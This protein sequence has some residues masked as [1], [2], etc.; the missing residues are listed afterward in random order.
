[1]RWRTRKGGAPVCASEA[2]P[3]RPDSALVHE[4][5]MQPII[6]SAA[7]S[8]LCA[9]V[10]AL[11]AG[12]FSHAAGRRAGKAEFIVAVQA[13]ASEVIARLREEIDRLTGRCEAAEAAC[14]AAK[15]HHRA[16]RD[17]L[18]ALWAEVRAKPVPAYVTPKPLRARRTR[19]AKP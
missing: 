16:C 4:S 15:E 11:V 14:Q 18:D 5:P 8:G 3:D 7:V 13:A 1:M 9:V 6:L 2:P 19:A 10:A 12:W 17:E